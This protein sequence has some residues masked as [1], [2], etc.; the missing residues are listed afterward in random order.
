MA[1]YL[2]CQNE[3]EASSNNNGVRD[4]QGDDIQGNRTTG[5]D[6]AARR[7]SVMMSAAIACA[8]ICTRLSVQGLK[9]CP[10]FRGS[11]LSVKPGTLGKGPASGLCLFKVVQRP[12]VTH[13]KEDDLDDVAVHADVIICRLC[14]CR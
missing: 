3:S 4:D 5:S 7:T 6:T 10:I 1:S 8:L 13:P 14:V 9:M 2:K 11:I 12:V